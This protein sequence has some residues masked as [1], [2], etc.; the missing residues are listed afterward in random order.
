[1]EGI[2][3]KL[4]ERKTEKKRKYVESFQSIKRTTE[5]RQDGYVH[6]L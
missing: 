2:L 6:L 4:L 1:M 5:P 3:R